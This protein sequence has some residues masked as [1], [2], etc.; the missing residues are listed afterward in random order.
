MNDLHRL[1]FDD[2]PS[3]AAALPDPDLERRIPD[4]QVDENPAT[5]LERVLR[6]LLVP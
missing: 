3:E 4:G 5:I 2:L 6:S 1:G